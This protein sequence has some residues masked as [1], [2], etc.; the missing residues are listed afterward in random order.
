MGRG[1]SVSRGVLVADGVGDAVGVAVGEG[2]G[3]GVGAPVGE[4]VG[5]GVGDEVGVA[6]GEGDGVAAGERV[7]AAAKVEEGLTDGVDVAVAD[8]GIGDAEA[9]PLGDGWIVTGPAVGLTDG[10]AVGAAV[11]PAF[12]TLS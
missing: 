11:S 10:D 9:L 7:G 6:L 4:A 2:V 8:A 3:V 1:G 5:D 12:G